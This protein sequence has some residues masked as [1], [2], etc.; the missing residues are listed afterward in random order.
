MLNS[1]LQVLADHG[2]VMCDEHSQRWAIHPTIQAV[3]AR[4]SPHRAA[5]AVKLYAIH[6]G[7]DVCLGDA[8]T[9]HVDHPLLLDE[10][11]RRRAGL[12]EMLRIQVVDDVHVG[13]V[14]DVDEEAKEVS[15]DDHIF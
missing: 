14:T 9:S 15:F 12:K 8:D 1:V 4:I 7:S 13:K 3:A 6:L 10:Q 2:W 5:A 11:R